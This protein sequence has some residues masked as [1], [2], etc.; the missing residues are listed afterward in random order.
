M[1]GLMKHVI[2]EKLWQLRVINFY[3]FTVVSRIALLTVI[4][5]IGFWLVDFQNAFPVAGLFSTHLL[6]L[7]ALLTVVDGIEQHCH[8]R[9]LT[10]TKP[11][12]D[13]H[14]GQPEVHEGERE[15]QGRGQE[16]KRAESTTTGPPTTGFAMGQKALPAQEVANSK[17]NKSSRVE[18][19][20]NKKTLMFSDKSIRNQSVLKTHLWVYI[21]VWINF[22]LVPC[23][24]S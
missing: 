4:I 2:L 13:T 1:I 15:G 8:S 23:S 5:T 20:I 16:R 14:E 7:D 22:Y 6:S 19:L 12:P 9:I 11:A 17:W 21:N 24:I 10:A 3:H 18:R